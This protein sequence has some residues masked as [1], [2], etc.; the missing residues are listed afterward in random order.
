[1]DDGPTFRASHGFL[2]AAGHASDL[3]GILEALERAGQELFSGVDVYADG[4]VDTRRFDGRRARHVGGLQDL[5][6]AEERQFLLAAGY[7][8]SRRIL[9]NAVA[10]LD[11]PFA[12]LVHPAATIGTL[13]TIAHGSAILAGAALSPR[14]QVGRH[15]VVSQTVSV[16]HD[17]IIGDFCSVMPTACVSGDCRL[18]SGVLIGSGAVVA[19][20]VSIGEN[21]VIG[22][23]A[24]VL[25]DVEAGQTMIGIPARPR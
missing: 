3:L 12:T 16:G 21:A 5:R 9:A 7:P 10:A 11:L 14:V 17:T 8:E 25:A 15:A 23:G 20:K 4:E 19:E 1:M 13:S 22:A 18:G 6:S 2:G 24:V